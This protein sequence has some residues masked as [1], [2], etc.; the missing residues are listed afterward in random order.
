MDLSRFQPGT[1]HAVLVLKEYTGEGKDGYAVQ[2]GDT[3]T[4]VATVNASSA[5]STRRPTASAPTSSAP[6]H[7][8]APAADDDDDDDDED[9][10]E[11][12]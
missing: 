2:A 3:S 4:A 11:E 6:R 7:P 8:A 9:D 5:A 1:Y 12:E 10:D